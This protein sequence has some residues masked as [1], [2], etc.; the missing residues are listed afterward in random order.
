MGLTSENVAKRFGIT[1]LEQDQAAVSYLILLFLVYLCVYETMSD[2]SHN[3]LLALI[4][5][6]C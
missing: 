5:F 3:M 4:I 6:N 2:L 1:R